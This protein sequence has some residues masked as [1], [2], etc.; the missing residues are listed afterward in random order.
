MDRDF[1]S[2]KH[3]YSAELYLEVLK[4][5]VALIFTGLGPGYE[6]MQDNASIYR[7]SKVKA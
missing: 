6:F 4:A 7:A 3:G 5:E 1:E 2:A